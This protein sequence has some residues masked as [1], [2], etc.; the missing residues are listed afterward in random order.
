MEKPKKVKTPSFILEL[1]LKVSRRNEKI[2]LSQ[3]ESARKLYNASLGEAKRRANLIRQS[4][5]FDKARKIPRAPKDSLKPKD[6]KNRKLKKDLFS[7]A[8]EAYD[9]NEYSLHK[10]IGELRHNLPNNLDIHT[11]QKLATRAFKAVEKILFGTARKVRFKG[12]NQL[13]SV[14]SK[15]NVAGIRWKNNRLEWGELSLEAIINKKDE[16]I[17][18]GLQHKVKYSRLY[19]KII[20]GKNKF[21]VQLVLQGKPLIKA[22]NK[23]GKGNV[24]YDLGPSTVGIVGDNGEVD[25]KREIINAKLLQFCSELDPRIKEIANLQ[26]KIDRQRRANNPDNFADGNGQGKIK[27]GRLIWRKSKHQLNNENK[28]KELH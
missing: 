24:C 14:E 19:R 7:K 2:I 28:L 18:H 23:L 5:I 11:T 8:R 25:E 1:P 12:F 13:N 20:K 21:Y 17:F 22:K 15:S 3:L 16:V 26:R 4:R 27:K 10:Y 9:F 6:I